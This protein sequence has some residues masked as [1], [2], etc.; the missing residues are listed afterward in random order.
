M[1]I[2]I[3]IESEVAAVEAEARREPEKTIGIGMKTD[4]EAGVVIHTKKVVKAE[5]KIAL[6]LKTEADQIQE[7]KTDPLIMGIAVAEIIRHRH[8]MKDIVRQ[9]VTI[10]VQVVPQHQR[11]TMLKMKLR[12]W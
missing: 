5:I 7:A 8:S 10:A 12:I 9:N 6:K 2:D 11:D 4:S 1:V 3:A